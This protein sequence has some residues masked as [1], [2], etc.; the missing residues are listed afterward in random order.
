LVF[1]TSTFAPGNPAGKSEW[2]PS[3]QERKSSGSN[4]G[5][6]ANILKGTIQG[7]TIEL[8]QESGLP[9]GQKVSVTL[10]PESPPGAGLRASFGSW[11]DDAEE[12]DHFLE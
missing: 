6:W 9:D 11:A 1:T 12:V 7:K 2:P 8:E 5:S 3:A 4:C 10:R